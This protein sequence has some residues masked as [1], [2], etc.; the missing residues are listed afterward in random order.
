MIVGQHFIK[1]RVVLLQLGL[2][3]FKAAVDLLQAPILLLYLPFDQYKMRMA[4]TIIV[5]SLYVLP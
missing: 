5:F 2:D 4:K 1:T 3:E